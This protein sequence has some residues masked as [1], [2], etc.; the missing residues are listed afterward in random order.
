M[1]LVSP[2]SWRSIRDDVTFLRAEIR[3]DLSSPTAKALLRCAAL[4]NRAIF[5]PDQEKVPIL[6]R[7]TIGDAS[8]SALLK[9]TEVNIGDAVAYRER[10]PKVCEIPFNSTNKYQVST[11]AGHMIAAK[12]GNISEK[13]RFFWIMHSFGRIIV[14]YHSNALTLYWLTTVSL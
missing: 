13:R 7:E 14:L 8:E 10:S 1:C 5:K 6:K 9:C 2:R 3:L 11:H 4:C 12:V